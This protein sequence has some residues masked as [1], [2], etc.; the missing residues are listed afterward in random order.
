MFIKLLGKMNNYKT[1][2]KISLQ[3]LF[4]YIGYTYISEKLTLL[5]ILIT[6][7]STQSL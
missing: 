4:D 3:N 1:L 2:Q 7:W 6:I 5:V